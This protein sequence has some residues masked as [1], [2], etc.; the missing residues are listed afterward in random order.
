MAV[1]V[2]RAGE[3]SA[4]WVKALLAGEP[5]AG[6]TR[7]SS[8]WVEPFFASAEG[9]LLSVAD[10]RTPATKI[11]S[12][13]DLREL[14]T[15]LKQEPDVRKQMLG[16]PVS[17]LIVDTLDEVGRIFMKERNAER[18]Q[19]SFDQRDWGWYGEQ[20]RG[21]VRE[22]RNLDMHVIFTVHLKETQDAETGRVTMKPAIQ[23]A[24][25]D[26]LPAYVDLAAVLTA[27]PT[28]RI[29]GDH[30]E[31][32]IARILQTYPDTRHPWIK[33]RSGRLPMELEINF[34]D[35]YERIVGLIFGGLDSA[36]HEVAVREA[37][38]HVA[39][40]AEQA[41]PAKKATKKAAPAE[42]KA[43]APKEDP[44]PTPEPEP[45][46]EP[47]TEP[48][49]APPA[50]EAEPET[51]PQPAEEPESAPEPEAAE[52]E[53]PAEQQ[54]LVSVDGKD[55][56]PSTGEVIP[57]SNGSSV[58]TPGTTKEPAADGEGLTC[59]ECRGP[60]ES[61]D[62]ADLSWIRFRKRMCRTCFAGTKKPA[63]KK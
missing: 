15:L 2:F 16:T 57:P 29:V 26:E 22:L 62:Q 8:T 46:P 7:T 3:E 27:R 39:A 5:G 33:D 14:V 28:T 12:S 61:E 41:A 10:R 60:I 23:G 34:D 56:D 59:Q 31:R 48:E 21:L 9:G 42:P 30:T 17:T 20:L 54:T 40:A 18:R 32:G 47:A 58:P 24:M 45:D 37:E 11:T 25:G 4:R 49:P 44:K 55:V 1:K 38:T 6:K 51:A 53:T 35:D 13:Q 63:A 52:P 43:E 36:D 19:E 50:P